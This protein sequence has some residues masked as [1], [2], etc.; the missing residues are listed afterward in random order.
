MLLFSSAEICPSGEQSN[1]PQDRESFDIETPDNTNPEDVLRGSDAVLPVVRADKI[2][3]TMN[4][5]PEEFTVMDVMYKATVPTR[6]R[7][8]RNDQ[9]IITLRNTPVSRKFIKKLHL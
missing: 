9:E 5:S 6:V 3:I 2:F 7:Y 8:I 1:L 4:D